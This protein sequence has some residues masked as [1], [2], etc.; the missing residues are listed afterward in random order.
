MEEELNYLS[1]K[2]DKIEGQLQTAEG[3]A[4]NS[5]G[6]QEQVEQLE[7]E[8]QLLLNIVD[9]ITINELK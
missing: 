7:K 9:Y 3:V 2:I 4:V 1:E 5:H 6:L 8:Q